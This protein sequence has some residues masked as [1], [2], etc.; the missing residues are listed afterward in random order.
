MSNRSLLPALTR[1]L[2]GATKVVVLGV[3]SELRADDAAGLRAA[4]RLRRMR[5]RDVQVLQAGTAPENVTGEIR[6][7]SP[8]HILVID[9]ADMGLSP[10]SIQVLEQDELGGSRPGT[11]GISL[12]VL[13]QY[14][15]QDM[16]FRAIVIGIQP[17]SL[18]AGGS[19]SAPV[20]E[21]VEEVARAVKEALGQ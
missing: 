19:V 3:G 21:A 20:S 2:E 9:A 13:L 18:E 7:L 15:S 6:R 14:L 12:G 4:E 5:L 10:G 8:S 1:T 16:S 11:H 17:S